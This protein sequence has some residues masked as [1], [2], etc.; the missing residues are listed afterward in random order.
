MR[1]ARITPKTL[2]ALLMMPTMSGDWGDPEPWKAP[3]VPESWWPI[4]REH[5]PAW[6]RALSQTRE[7]GAIAETFRQQS[8]VFRSGHPASSFAARGPNAQRLTRQHDLA[9]NMGDTSPLGRLNELDGHVLLLGVGHANNSSLHLAEY[10]ASY[11]GKRNEMQGAAIVIDGKRKWVEYETLA[12]KDDDF[13][14]IGL[15]FEEQTDDAAVGRVG[16][17]ESRLM[18]QRPLVE[19][20]TKWMNDNR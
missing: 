1:L 11:T 12:L 17:A 8:G 16:L 20:A 14:Q 2:A 4:I 18:R 15:A 5:W 7:M 3:P 19:F 13:A 6:D 10:R 9:G